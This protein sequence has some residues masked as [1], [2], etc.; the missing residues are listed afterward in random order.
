[1][2]EFIENLWFWFTVPNYLKVAERDLAASQLHLRQAEAQA[3]YSTLMIEYYKGCIAR[4]EALLVTQ[5]TE[6]VATAQQATLFGN[7]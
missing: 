3:H 4:D 2:I 7:S 1:M 5:R 6:D